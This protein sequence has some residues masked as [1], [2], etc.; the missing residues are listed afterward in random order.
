MTTGAAAVGW[1]IVHIYL[2]HYYM[3][4][5]IPLTTGGVSRGC[6]KKVAVKLDRR[7]RQQTNMF[8]NNV[9]KQTFFLH[10]VCMYYVFFV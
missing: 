8:D 6:T 3:R 4:S 5:C 7:E 1:P 10:L 2:Q 9:D